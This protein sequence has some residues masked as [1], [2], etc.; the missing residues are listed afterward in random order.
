[1]SVLGSS[2]RRLSTVAAVTA[3][4]SV[5]SA[6][7]IGATPVTASTTAGIVVSAVA[8]DPN[9][10]YWVAP[11]V[12]TFRAT[13]QM[14]ESEIAVSREGNTIVVNELE[15][16]P[17]LAIEAPT[18]ARITCTSSNPSGL[19][20]TIRCTF[21]G[22]TV[23]RDAGVYGDFDAAPRGV[24]FGLDATSQLNSM[25]AGSR[26]DDYLQGGSAIDLLAGG[27]GD[28]FL[29]GGAG[30]DALLG[31]PGDDVIYGDGEDAETGKDVLVGG[32]GDDFLEGGPA[33][34]RMIGGPGRDDID[35]KD[36]I[37]DEELDCNDSDSRGQESEA[38]RFDRN[39]DR[40]I[41]C[42]GVELPYPLSIPSVTPI[43]LVKPNTELTATPPQWGGST[44]M[45][46]SYRWESCAVSSS[47]VPTDCTERAKGTLNAQGRDSRTGRAP[48][49]SVRSQD[50]KRAIQFIVTADNRKVK[51]GG[52]EEAASGFVDVGVQSYK[53]P[54]GLLPRQG[55]GGAW[56]FASVSSVG[57][58]LRGVGL[59]DFAS[60]RETPWRRAAVPASQRKAIRDGGVFAILI[61]GRE[62]KAGT[63]IEG[64]DAA[65]ASVEIRYYATSE[66]RKTCPVSGDDL[67]GLRRQAETANLA[68]QTVSDYLDQRKCPWTVAWSTSTGRSTVFT[69]ED[70]AVEET[71]DPEKP[72][73]V[74]ITARRPGT[75]PQLSIAVGAPPQRSVA[76]SPEQFAIG[77]NGAV[78]A[79]PGTVFTS[80]WTSLVGDQARMP[81]KRARVQLFVNGDLRVQGE[82]GADYSYD[83]A[84]VF[85]E[86]GVARV[87]ITTLTDSGAPNAQVYVD[88]PILD[89]AT[90]PLGDLITWDGRCFDREGRAA[91]CVGRIPNSAAET[92]RGAMVRTGLARL[93]TY[94]AV[95]ALRLASRDIDARFTPVIVN[96]PVPS[97]SGGVRSSLIPRAAC[98]WWDL[99]CHLRGVVSQV[100]EAFMKP[101]SMAKPQT[102][103][104]RGS[105]VYAEDGTAIATIT[106]GRV[107][108][109]VGAGL[110]GLDGATLIG[111]DG[112]T[113]ISDQGGSLIG[114]DG[115]TLIGL[116][117]ATLIGLDGATLIGLDG[118]TLRPNQV[119]LPLISAGGMN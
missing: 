103:R 33:S 80:I 45:T 91:S 37:A 100:V 11:N 27:D 16:G 95:D 29:Y 107:A 67:A 9:G 44:P 7:L 43:E 86:P 68:L 23:G 83:L 93:Q 87:V 74:R 81:T 116:D 75:G 61:N 119:A 82:Q 97:G 39:L 51:G 105:V 55:G 30:D 63:A 78:Y 50:N 19:S 3:A 35:A 46:L 53:V 117:S 40:P 31:G 94:S 101:K 66:D 110:I 34:D 90:A 60:I 49:Y 24:T 92:I 6:L 48:T 112:A 52:A 38:P 109:V 12:V 96:G 89:S 2:R 79:F 28:D 22:D 21:G 14:V 32:P 59:E 65:K 114:L 113:L 36:G 57:S 41:D 26:F 70:L 13:P 15:G 42:G 71:D 54:A 108:N 64:S 5:G 69:V 62:A 17:S 73:Q 25:I 98:A 56:S 58:A 4:V 88:I 10:A 18:D 8:Q 47:G 111:L 104:V 20:D 76:Q 99:G 106:R 84:T 85:T 118:A 102:F 115:A 77:L 1:M 72:V